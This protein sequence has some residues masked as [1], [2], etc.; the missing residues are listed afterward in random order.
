M[1]AV[2]IVAVNELRRDVLGWSMYVCWQWWNCI[3]L[4]T[5]RLVWSYLDLL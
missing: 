4:G 3:L 5:T 1:G 2:G